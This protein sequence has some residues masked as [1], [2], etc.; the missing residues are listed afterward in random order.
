MVPFGL[1]QSQFSA[2][3]KRELDHVSPS[4]IALLCSLF[5]RPV[6]P[7]VQFANVEVFL[8][9]YGGA[10]SVWIYY[11]GANNRVEHT[12]EALFAG[13]SL[14]LQLP[15]SELAEFDERYFL[16][17]EDGDVEFPG[18]MLAANVLK[19]WFAE[20]WWK[21]GGW[22]YSLPTTVKV[23]DDWGDGNII[24]LTEAAR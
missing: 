20:C 12:N 2:R 8:D 14:D 15:L 1:T 6:N 23:H 19:S 4:V 10:P 9:E 17:L 5:T 3:Y 21:A 18:L 16:S 11:R 22:T 13:R 24:L 7:D